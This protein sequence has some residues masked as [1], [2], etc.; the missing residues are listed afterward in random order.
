MRFPS[1]FDPVIR[2]LANVARTIAKLILQFVQDALGGY[3][4]ELLKFGLKVLEN[5]NPLR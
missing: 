5:L 2:S 1:W 3:A 4:L